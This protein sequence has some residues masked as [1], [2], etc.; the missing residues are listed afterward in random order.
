M[1]FKA[2]KI[3]NWILYPK[4]YRDLISSLSL[5]KVSLFDLN[6]ETFKKEIFNTYRDIFG[7]GGDHEWGEYVKCVTCNKIY[8]VEQTHR[9]KDYVHLSDLPEEL[10]LS[11]CCYTVFEYFHN[12]NSLDKKFKSLLCQDDAIMYVLKDINRNRIIGLIVGCV[13]SIEVAWR[14]YIEDKLILRTSPVFD[15]SFLKERVVYIDE[16]GIIKSYRRGRFPFFTL[17]NAFLKTAYKSPKVAKILFWTHK[18]SKLYH[19]TQQLK[20]FIVVEDLESPPRVV[21]TMTFSLVCR[22]V[23]F[24]TMIYT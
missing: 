12:E 11:H 4:E 16:V 9:T 17:F 1:I 15:H 14:E 24:V 3:K 2:K 20:H 6:N 13:V 19:L 10:P 21:I 5:V 23:R 18:G 7:H 8:D 22:M